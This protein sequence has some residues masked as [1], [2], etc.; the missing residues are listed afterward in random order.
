MNHSEYLRRKLESLPKTYGPARLGDESMKTMVARYKASAGCVTQPAL[1]APTCCQGDKLTWRQNGG[2]RPAGGPYVRI[3]A[4]QQQEYG[5]YD[6][7]RDRAAGQAI[8]GGGLNSA[9]HTEECCPQESTPEIPRTVA[10]IPTDPTLK[11]AALQGHTSCCPFLT[12]ARPAGPTDCEC[13]VGRMNTLWAND[14]PTDRIIPPAEKPCC[15]ITFPPYVDPC[16][17]E[18]V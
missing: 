14:M 8:C 6:S 7:V 2:G 11:A 1:A 17:P 12:A 13:Q 18:I 9:Y 3:G 4:G 5:S 10:G 16:P 15:V